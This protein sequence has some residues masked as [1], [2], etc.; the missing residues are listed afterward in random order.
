MSMTI[1]EAHAEIRRLYDAAATI[2]NK[3]PNGL[4]Q[5]EHAEDYAEAKRLLGEID[6]LE[7][8]LGGLE[9]ADARKR[10]ILDNQK[11]LAR[12]AQPHQHPDPNERGS[13]TSVAVKMFGA[14]FVE[15]SEYTNIIQSG[16]LNNPSNRVEMGVKLD[17]SLLDYLIHKALVYSGSGVGGPLIRPDRVSGLDFLYRQTTL[18]DLIPTAATTS[19]S[20]E[21]YEMTT[22]TNNAA[23]VAEAT[24]STGTTGT[25]PEGGV[26]WTLRTLPVATIAEWMPVTNQMLADAPAVRG[27][28]D[29]T[30]LTHL[31]LAL[32][33]Q[34][35]SGNGTAPNM[36]GILSNPSIL[37]TGLGAGA[38][39]SIDAV[40]HAMTAVMAT[41]LSNPTASVWNPIDFEVVRLARENAASATL[42]GYLIGPPNV[43]GPT[44]LWGRPVILSLG[45]P[46]D[47]ALV[48]DFQ[49]AMMLFDREQAAIR[50]GLANDDF[51]RNIQRVLAELRAVFA[52][53]RPTAACR[54]T[55]V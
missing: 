47:T 11:R 17:G 21:Y 55:G 31:T 30:L 36:L 16:V 38:G 39:T 29:Q 27:I 32:E 25:K 51:L 45:M 9:E 52:L 14:Q 8:K 37:T 54:V 10:R 40:Y 43:T 5:D 23:P 48:A 49:G 1:P 20:I 41:G 7:Q 28:I 46:V 18:L 34:V 3:Y 4:T 42:G 2:E 24:N 53:F 50:V 6:G 26:G 22:S 35:L 19:N 15:S 12:P 33:T 13:E 44:T